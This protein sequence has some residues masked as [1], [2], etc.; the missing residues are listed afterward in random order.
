MQL[1]DMAAAGRR[2][3]AIQAGI[4]AALQ[5]RQPNYYARMCPRSSVP[6]PSAP[7]GWHGSNLLARNDNRLNTQG[8]IR[9]H[10]RA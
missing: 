7:E 6:V 9:L 10:L 5:T 1:D 4:V 8:G 3:A 2:F